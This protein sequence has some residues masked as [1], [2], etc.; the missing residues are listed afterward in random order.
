[1]LSPKLPIPPTLPTLLP[2][3]FFFMDNVYPV[4]WVCGGKVV[5]ALGF[6]KKLKSW[7]NGEEK[8]I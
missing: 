3:V 4:F 2:L 1:M 7:V 6:G 5:L 8:K